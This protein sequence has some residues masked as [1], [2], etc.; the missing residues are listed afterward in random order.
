M[1]YDREKYVARTRAIMLGQLIALMSFKD[2]AKQRRLDV[3]RRTPESI[4]PEGNDGQGLFCGW[5]RSSLG[6]LMGLLPFQ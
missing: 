5:K 1:L 4:I 6:G 3:K 2:A